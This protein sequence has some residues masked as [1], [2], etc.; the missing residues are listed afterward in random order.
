MCYAAQSG[1][2]TV[3]AAAAAASLAL[4]EKWPESNKI[5]TFEKSVI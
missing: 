4:A 1:P 5:N 2:H 3:Y